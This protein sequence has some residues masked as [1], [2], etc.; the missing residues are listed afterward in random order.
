MNPLERI[1]NQLCGCNEMCNCPFGVGDLRDIWG[2]AELNSL[3]GERRLSD[4][5][6]AFTRDH[7]VRTVS[8]L[9][10]MNTPDSELSALIMK[11]ANSKERFDEK[12]PNLT[13]NDLS[14]LPIR[15]EHQKVFKA[16][17][18]RFT[19]PVFEEGKDEELRSGQVMP[20][21]GRAEDEGRG[22]NGQVFSY[23]VA[24]GHLILKDIVSSTCIFLKRQKTT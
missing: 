18:F 4:E 2:E 16:L 21:Q 7:L 1:G 13:E 10:Y 24:K 22:M 11:W 5:Q 9:R 14:C 19:A 12:L 3:M 8:L 15:A 20:F 23:Y 17:M 6:V